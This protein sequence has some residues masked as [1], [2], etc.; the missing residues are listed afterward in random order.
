M[1]MQ[2]HNLKNIILNENFTHNGPDCMIP[3]IWN[4][5]KINL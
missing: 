2:E 5:G 4:T 1:H 3:S